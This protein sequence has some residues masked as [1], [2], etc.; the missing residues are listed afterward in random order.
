MNMKVH[1]MTTSRRFFVIQ[2]LTGAGVLVA[3]T[4][5]LTAA[6]QTT[7]NE[8]D[9][10]AVALGYRSDGS[11]ADVKKYPSY[12]ASQSCSSCVLFQGKSTEA[13][14][15]CPIFGNK[16][17]SAKAWCGAWAKKG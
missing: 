10:Q 3:L 11:K 1:Q 15:N 8:T 16:Q 7:V 9:A 2:S 13:T 17:V 14:G 12:D 4:T 5:P 6:A